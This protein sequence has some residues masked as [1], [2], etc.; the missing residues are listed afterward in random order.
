M[1]VPTD[2][3]EI[4]SLKLELDRSWVLGQDEG[5]IERERDASRSL[6][7][8][9]SVSEGARETLKREDSSQ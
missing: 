5:A 8:R 4:V 7:T 2:V 6:R 3:D 9:I 1:R